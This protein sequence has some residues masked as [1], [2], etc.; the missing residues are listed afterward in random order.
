MICSF[1]NFNSNAN[2]LKLITLSPTILQNINQ[3]LLSIVSTLT[4]PIH[5]FIQKNTLY[6]ILHIVD[7]PEKAFS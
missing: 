3:V 1:M 2:Y 7:I 4:D 5:F 6:F